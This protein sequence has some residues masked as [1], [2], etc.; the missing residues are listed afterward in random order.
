LPFQATIC[1]FPA[2]NN[3]YNITLDKLKIAGW[4]VSLSS[5]SNEVLPAILPSPLN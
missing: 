2:G 5:S 1:L 4:G 3:Y